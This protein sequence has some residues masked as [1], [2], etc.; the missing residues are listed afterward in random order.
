MRNYRNTLRD[1]LPVL[2]LDN[3][4]RP[5][6]P[7][8]ERVKFCNVVLN[9]YAENLERLIDGYKEQAHILSAQ[10]VNTK[11][12]AYFCSQRCIL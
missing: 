3:T 9:A 10:N 12:Y 7:Y 6:D 5:I 1:Q 8:M 4:P 2:W 11:M